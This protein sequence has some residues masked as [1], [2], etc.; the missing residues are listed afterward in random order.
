MQT[1]LHT[2]LSLPDSLALHQHTHRASH[3]ALLTTQSNR[4]LRHTDNLCFQLT[5][6]KTWLDKQ[7]G[8]QA[9][10]VK[11]QKKIP[12]A[13]VS[14]VSETRR[15]IREADLL[16]LHP[17]STDCCGRELKPIHIALFTDCL[18]FCGIRQNRD[19]PVCHCLQ[20]AGDGGHNTVVLGC[21]TYG[22]VHATSWLP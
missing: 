8:Y 4:R 5:R 17:Q 1:W 22:A 9:D 3:T 6:L 19:K 10:L 12:L 13:E 11:F 15:M 20:R 2:A 21:C 16:K 7:I 14:I 18:V